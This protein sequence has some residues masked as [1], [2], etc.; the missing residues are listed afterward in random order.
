MR[1]AI[2]G[3]KWFGTEVFKAAGAYGTVDYV[4]A[5]EAGDRLALA[6]RAARVDVHVRPSGLRRPFDL[7]AVDVLISAH[8]FLYV[9]AWLRGR[10][11]WSIGYHPSLLPLHRGRNAV[12]AAIA[13]GDRVTGGT[14]YLLEGGYDTGSVVFQDWCFIQHGETDAGLWRRA[15]APMGLELL[16]KALSHLDDH[17][18][19]DAAP[20]EALHRNRVA[21]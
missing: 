18:R 13:A 14:V 11:S 20:Q 3:Q 17:G 16:E 21:S 7:P 4:I 19:L 2:V 5:P 6:A 9:P 8:S 12:A 1:I 10:A 15:L